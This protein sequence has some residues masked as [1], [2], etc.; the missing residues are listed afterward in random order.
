MEKYIKALD[1]IMELD[2]NSEDVYKE[3]LDIWRFIREILLMYG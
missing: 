1:E 2:G 3:V